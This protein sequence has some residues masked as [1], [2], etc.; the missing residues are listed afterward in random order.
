MAR[1]P[2]TRVRLQPPPSGNRYR[3]YRRRTAGRR[4][5][6][7]AAL[8]ALLAVVG[9][10]VRT[11]FGLDGERS[12]ESQATVSPSPLPAATPAEVAPTLPPATASPSPAAAV[13]V[14]PV[15]TLTPASAILPV[16]GPT[17]VVLTAGVGCHS[18]PSA[19][20]TVVA[21]VAGRGAGDGRVH[22]AGRRRVAARGGAR[23]LASRIHP[24]P[25]GCV[26][27]T[28]EAAEECARLSVSCACAHGRPRRSSRRPAPHRGAGHPAPLPQSPP[29]LPRCRPP[30]RRRA[31]ATPV[32]TGLWTVVLYTAVPEQGETRE[33]AGAVAAEARAAGFAADVIA[34][35]DYASLRPGYWVVVSGRYRTQGEASAQ[36]GRLRDGRLWRRRPRACWAPPLRHSARMAARVAATSRRRALVI[37]FWVSVS[38]L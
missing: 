13:T 12:G 3:P 35:S 4:W 19:A 23:L 21:F 36:L 38:R 29:A 20:A 37:G 30:L 9:F 18:E 27:Q 2:S 33:T 11:G 32:A 17:F 15:P 6:H 16:T 10:G 8:V 24:G 22:G 14:S 34:S 7:V 1:P 31:R 28:L 26:T 5:L 25:V